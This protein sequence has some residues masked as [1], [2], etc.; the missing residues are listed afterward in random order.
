MSTASF[1]GSNANHF[2]SQNITSIFNISALPSLPPPNSHGTFPQ[3]LWDFICLIFKTTWEEV[4]WKGG[5]MK[6]SEAK[7][8][9]P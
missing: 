7:G 6:G 5:E 9:C 1:I 3:H 2:L 4:K 8:G